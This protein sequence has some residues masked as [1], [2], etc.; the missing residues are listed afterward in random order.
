MKKSNEEKLFSL[1]DYYVFDR[2][3][4]NKSE[5]YIKMFSKDFEKNININE[6]TDVGMISLIVFPML[7]Q[8]ENYYNEE[9]C[10]SAGLVLSLLEAENIN[11]RIKSY[12]AENLIF[13]LTSI[14]D[15]Y[16]NII[17]EYLHLEIPADNIIKKRIINRHC[18]NVDFVKDGKIIKV[19]EKPLPIE[20]QKRIRKESRTKIKTLNKIMLIN[21]ISHRF[22]LTER[23]KEIFSIMDSDCIEQ[24]K[25]IRNQI[26]HRRALGA[27]ISPDYDFLGQSISIN[28]KGWCDFN[29]LS[30]IIKLNLNVITKEIQLI[31]EVIFF[32][33]RP[34]SIE[35]KDKQYFV[36]K[37]KCKDCGKESILPEMKTIE[38][39]KIPCP[40]CWK[41]EI[42]IIDKFKTNELNYGGRMNNHIKKFIEHLD[43]IT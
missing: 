42:E 5:G 10:I 11:L 9:I 21:T 37:V 20:E 28:N 3:I 33:E 35:N 7:K 34:N 25:H 22:H 2:K 43:N 12:H 23:F 1:K 27:G 6:H 17:N 18:V 31:H 38:E 15:Y 13:R 41:H 36:I 26:V 30:E 40:V 14:W 4:M 39:Q 32:D 24:L 16:Y 8:L 19:V 29:E